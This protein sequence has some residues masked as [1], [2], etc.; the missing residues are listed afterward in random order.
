MSSVDIDDIN[1]GIIH[2]LQK[3][4]RTPLTDIADHVDVSDNTVR[5]RIQKLEDAG[6]IEGYTTQINYEAAGLE[7]YYI[8]ICTV[9]VG[10]REELAERAIDFPGVID[11]RTF[12]TGEQNVHITAAKGSK[13]EITDLAYQIDNAG[14]RIDREH[15]IWSHSRRP[16][17]EFTPE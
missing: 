8:F 15:L 2:L 13:Q 1:R 12:M 14:L 10:N 16:S 17:S 7:H 5:N 11:V 6:V 4:S 3:D 9:R